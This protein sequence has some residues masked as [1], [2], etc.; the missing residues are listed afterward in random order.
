MLVHELEVGV[1]CST[2]HSLLPVSAKLWHL[3]Y[4]AVMALVDDHLSG[5]QNRRLLIWSLLN[6]EGLL[7]RYF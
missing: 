6:V 2:M 1:K 7:E 5:R 4:E 3:D